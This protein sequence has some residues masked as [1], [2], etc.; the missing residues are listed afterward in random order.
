MHVDFI[1]VFDYRCAVEFSMVGAEYPSI[2]TYNFHKK[3]GIKLTN[4]INVDYEIAKQYF[5]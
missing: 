3:T 2:Y 5:K 4:N 1:S